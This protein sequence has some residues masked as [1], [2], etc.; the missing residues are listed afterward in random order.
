MTNEAEDEDTWRVKALCYFGLTIR[1]DEPE[2]MTTLD[3]SVT[4]S[5]L[6]KEP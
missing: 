1:S 5:P 2:T 3:E 4:I 6:P